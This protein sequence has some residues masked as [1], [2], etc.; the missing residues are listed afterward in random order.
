L[1]ARQR[2]AFIAAVEQPRWVPSVP[3]GQVLSGT[4]T[5]RSGGGFHVG[6]C[7][8]SMRIHH[9]N[10]I[11]SCP[12][13]GRL[14]EMTGRRACATSNACANC[15]AHGGEVE[16]FCSHDVAEFEKLAGHSARMPAERTNP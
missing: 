3:S 14:I 11:S 13:G 15:A 6:A 2:E 5:S 9:P 10:C 1:L 8:E 16:L 7:I 12:H 4:G